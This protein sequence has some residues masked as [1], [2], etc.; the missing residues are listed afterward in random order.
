MV[1]LSLVVPASDAAFLRDIAAQARRPARS[2]PS[3]AVGRTPRRAGLDADDL[4]LAQRW[5]T[6]SGLKLR[7]TRVGL[8]MG[9][10]LA[11]NIAHEIAMARWPVGANLG[12]E[13]ELMKRYGVRRSLLR[14][15]VRLLEYQSVAAMRRGVAGGL[16]VTEPSFDSA[17][18]PAGVF[19]ES[20]GFSVEQWLA[21]R[22]ALELHI[23]DRC[24]SLFDDA[25]RE[26]LKRCLVAES[27]LDDSASGTDLQRFPMTLAHLTGDPALEL[28]LD[29]LLRKA[30]FESRYYRAPRAKRLEVV[31]SLHR[32]HSA[33]ARGLI[34]G[35]RH[36]AVLAMGERHEI[37]AR[38]LI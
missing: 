36:R 26:A 11:R 17:A 5:A 24:M 18:Y 34:S 14:E 1:S 27:E 28:F 15:A 31:K 10:V 30:R 6:R 4:R 35:N 13:A 3:D 9:E 37:T 2:A 7:L 21:T 19:L 16:I 32:A 23:L 25:A 12:T 33:V 38:W 8:R 22:R 29:V 20:R